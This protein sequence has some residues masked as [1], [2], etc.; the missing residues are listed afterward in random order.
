MLSLPQGVHVELSPASVLDD[1]D[2]FSFPRGP[3]PTAPL[4]LDLKLSSPMELGMDIVKGNC[5]SFPWSI[6]NMPD[7]P[8]VY[9]FDCLTH[10]HDP[11]IPPD[12]RWEVEWQYGGGNEV[13]GSSAPIRGRFEERRPLQ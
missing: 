8:G 12:D 9:R 6:M 13:L 5:L 11:Q 10:I 1:Q 2:P 4:S 7:E 3:A